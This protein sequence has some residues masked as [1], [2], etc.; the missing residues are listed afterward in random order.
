MSSAAGSTG[1]ACQECKLRND[2][3]AA[4]VCAAC[5]TERRGNGHPRGSRRAASV[6]LVIDLTGL[7]GDEASAKT[8]GG[9][10]GEEDDDA[11]FAWEL[12]RMFDRAS[13]PVSVTTSFS[14]SSITNSLN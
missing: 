13:A 12:Q 6:R 1:W 2:D 11:V 10:K 9:V 14:S 8:D 7:D 4:A 3:N 5:G